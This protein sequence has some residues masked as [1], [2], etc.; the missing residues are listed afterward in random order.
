MFKKTIVRKKNYYDSVTLMSLTAKIKKEPGVEQVVIAMATEM[1]IE[2][3][4]QVDTE[5]L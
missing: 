4:T 2:I 5:K 1:N 3:P